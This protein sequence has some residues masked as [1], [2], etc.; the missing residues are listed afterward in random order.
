MIHRQTHPDLDVEGCF[1][2]K[3]ANTSIAGSALGNAD[4]AARNLIEKHWSKDHDAYKR[5][6]A[7]GVQPRSSEGAAR[8]EATANTVADVTR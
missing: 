7:N 4:S 6:R 5:L 8:L 3:I 1:A 2:C